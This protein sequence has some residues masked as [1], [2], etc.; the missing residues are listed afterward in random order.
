MLVKTLL[1]D[2]EFEKKKAVLK[3]TAGIVL[4]TE[5]PVFTEYNLSG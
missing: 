2:F 5:N 1:G 3:S 4:F